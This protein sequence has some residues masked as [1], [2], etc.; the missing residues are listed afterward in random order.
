[1]RWK[2]ARK[3]VRCSAKGLSW[4]STSR[5]GAVLT[6]LLV[7][8][9]AASLGPAASASTEA[10]AAPLL[11]PRTSTAPGK[12]LPRVG[13]VGGSV[14]QVVVSDLGGRTL[15]SGSKVAVAAKRTARRTPAFESMPK[16]ASPAFSPLRTV[17]VTTRSQFDNAWAALKPGDYIDVRGVS[18]VGEAVFAKSLP[19]PAELHFD[20]NVRFLGAAAGSRLPAV[21]VHDSQN[22][23]FFG[24]DVTGAGNDGIRLDDNV[25]VL[26][27]D[28]EVHDT[29][30]TGVTARGIAHSTSGLDLRGTISRCGYDLSL[31]PHAEK[32]TG[33][34]GVNLGTGTGQIV[35]NSR[36]VL[37]VH[38]Q[39]FG[40]AVEAQ[41]VQSSKLYLDARRITFQA[42]TQTGGNA[43]Q[44]W[45]P[46]SKGLDVPYLYADTLAGQ[47]VAADGGLGSTNSG[48]TV[49]HARVSN[50]RSSTKYEA[51]PAISYGDVR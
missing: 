32:G 49:E 20:S 13:A 25:D 9:V 19:A 44:L 47:A 42:K 10:A 7:L 17:V 29:A 26:W 38:D 45:G 6:G 11:S 28:F 34:H 15:A 27:W 8:G 12:V 41:G 4:G 18:F 21:W 35:T 16:F 48:I 51:D 33:N 40:A 1:M 2:L 43:L 24:G 14:H 36:F 5:T 37:T 31:D 22:V 30:G 3:S 39:A 50:V 46:S 23:R